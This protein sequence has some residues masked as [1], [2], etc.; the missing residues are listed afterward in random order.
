M[1]PIEDMVAFEFYK[2]QGSLIWDA[3][4]LDFN[5]DAVQY[6][7]A[8][9][10][11]R[12]IYRQFLGFFAPGDG[13]I[14]RQALR[15]LSQAKTYSESAFILAQ[16]YI[17]T[18]HSEAYGLA[19]T[20]VI[21]DRDEQEEVFSEIERLP[22]V[23]RKG[24]FVE[25]W[26]DNMSAPLGVRYLAGAFAEGV[27]FASLFAMIFYFRR[28]NIFKT[29]VTAN[30]QIMNDENLHNQFC[31]TMAK[32]YGGFT[33][34][35]AHIIAREAFEIESAHV[36]YILDEPIDSVEADT[37]MGLTKDAVKDYVKTLV[38]RTLVF[39]GVEPLYKIEAELAW[40][41]DM[42]TSYRKN[43]FYE[44]SLSGSSYQQM[45]VKGS[46]AAAS[47]AG[48]SE[49]QRKIAAIAEA[50]VVNPDEVDF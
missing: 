42:K 28:K 1:F 34:E 40:M 33:R 29:F 39:A 4:E 19:I 47:S 48:D 44:C 7:S 43:N 9:S 10:R 14:T 3:G 18:V 17:E 23:A 30:E 31:A 32:R 21:A 50:S 46:I 27:F 2:K 6:A 37:A 8:P 49:A 13:L 16:L 45:S 12:R 38:D 15:F 20:N 25:R 24:E 36:D 22:C 26:M 35:A 5:A 41:K 11:Y